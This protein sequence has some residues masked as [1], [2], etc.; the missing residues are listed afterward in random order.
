VGQ[1]VETRRSW[2]KAY[3]FNDHFTMILRAAESAGVLEG[4]LGASPI[5]EIIDE[6]G[7][8]SVP[9]LPA[10]L[11]NGL[12]PSKADKSATGSIFDQRGFWSEVQRVYE[13]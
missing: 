1:S 6:Y 12:R 10:A 7:L 5:N 13:N 11:R 4:E 3:D 9:G 8:T 2:E